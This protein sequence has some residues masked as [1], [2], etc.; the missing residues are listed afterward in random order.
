MIQDV[1]QGEVEASVI[2]KELESII[3][4]CIDKHI[5]H[6]NKVHEQTQSKVEFDYIV[7][8][9]SIII[10]T[11]VVH[12]DE[13]TQ[14][15]TYSSIASDEYYN[16]N[17]AKACSLMLLLTDIQMLAL[18]YKILFRGAISIG[19]HYRSER[20]MFSKALVKAYE[21]ES[22]KAIYPR[23]IIDQDNN[24][25]MFELYSFINGLVNTGMLLREGNEVFVDYLGRVNS[26]RHISP[27]Y[28]AYRFKIHKT[29]IEENL[30][31]Y[32][33]NEK[34]LVKYIWMGFYHNYSCINNDANLKIDLDS[35]IEYK[36][37][38]NREMIIP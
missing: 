6:F 34:V 9:D 13:D 1:E 33:D 31:K 4:K 20:V 28:T 7:F 16:I 3:Q 24:N 18:E 11:A 25:D 26:M 10:S 30:L 37:E 19:N 5:S 27:D 22:H 29:I 14:K 23:I 8:S 36:R 15:H 35:Y 17:Y 12:P 2:I 21:A 38:F 32:K